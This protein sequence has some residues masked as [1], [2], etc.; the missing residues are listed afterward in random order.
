[1]FFANIWR[2]RISGDIEFRRPCPGDAAGMFRLAISAGSL[3]VNSAYHYLLL[4]Q[5]FSHTSVVGV[6]GGDVIGFLTAFRCPDEPTHLFIWQIAVGGAHRR[7]GVARQMLDHLLER[8]FDP[9]VEY[10]EATVTP[11]NTASRELLLGLAAGRGW[12]IEENLL[13]DRDLFPD[14]NHEPEILY[15]IGPVVTL[16]SG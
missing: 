8:A 4:C 16:N 11:T 2:S 15:R 1:M 5:K 7:R 10:I 6:S 13:F 9:P 12:G 3:D 14:G